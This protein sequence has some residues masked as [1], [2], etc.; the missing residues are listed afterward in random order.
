MRLNN[1]AIL[2][3]DGK[4]ICIQTHKNI[5]TISYEKALY[6]Y[7]LSCIH[8][9]TT[10]PLLQTPW[11]YEEIEKMLISV[12]FFVDDEKY[13]D[14]SEYLEAHRFGNNPTIAYTE[15][16]PQELKRIYTEKEEVFTNTFVVSDN[17]IID[18]GWISMIDSWDYISWSTRFWADSPIENTQIND[19]V[20]I[21]LLKT[22]FMKNTNNH[23]KYWSWGGMY[24]TFPI[25]IN[26][27]NSVILYDFYKNIFYKSFIPNIYENLISTCILPSQN[28][29][30]KYQSYMLLACNPSLVF[31]KYGNRGYRYMYF[32]AGAIWT[33]IRIFSPKLW[34]GH[35]EIQGY[36]D[37]KTQTLLHTN[38]ILQKDSAIVTHLI[39]LT[40]SN[41]YW[42]ER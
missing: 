7:L 42:N 3:T 15:I 40:R 21:C 27:N 26:N 10:K 1:L 17:E 16:T 20:L 6:E 36:F 22:I 4:D 5:L 25:I 23:L 13:N 35:L 29:F 30:R 34:L 32:E 19:D 31:Q 9:K 12:W 18:D 24:A 2:S 8:N 38:K 33:L 39:W 37:E 14:A 28:N 41:V 11:H